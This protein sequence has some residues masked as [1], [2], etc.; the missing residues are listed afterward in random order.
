MSG[1]GSYDKM[2]H[3]KRIPVEPLK[4]IGE[5]KKE[6][7]ICREH[8]CDKKAISLCSRCRM[9]CYCSRE[10][11]RKHWKIHKKNCN[12]FAKAQKYYRGDD[13]GKYIGVWATRYRSIKNNKL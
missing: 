6:P 13:I 5:V 10:C 7:G 3:L 8:S 1:Y 4:P 11:I 9:N 2:S 12:R